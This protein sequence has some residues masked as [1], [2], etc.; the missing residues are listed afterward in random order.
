MNDAPV[1]WYKTQRFIALCQ[2]TAVL[3]LGWVSAALATNDWA[4]RPIAI[5]VVGNVLVGLKDWWSPNVQAPFA[6]MNRNNN[7]TVSPASVAD[8]VKRGEP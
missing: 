4:W 2:S 3:V 5:A 8:A 7:A 6:V 1:V